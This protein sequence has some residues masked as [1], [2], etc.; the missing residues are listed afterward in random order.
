VRFS[1]VLLLCG[2]DFRQVVHTHVPLSP[3]NGRRRFATGK[4]T[5][6]EEYCQVCTMYVTHGLE[7]GDQHRPYG[8]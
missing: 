3:V 2:N 6:G 4:V 7:T 5:A 1:A 8:R